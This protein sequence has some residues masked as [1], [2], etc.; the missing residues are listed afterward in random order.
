MTMNVVFHYTYPYHRDNNKRI[1]RIKL[2]LGTYNQDQA[3]SY[4]R[5]IIGDAELILYYRG[6][7]VLKIMIIHVLYWYHWYLKQPG[8]GRFANTIHQM[9]YWK[10]LTTQS[11]LSVTTCEKFQQFD[12]QKR[13]YVHLLPEVIADINPCNLL[14]IDLIGTYVKSIRTQQ[15]GGVILQN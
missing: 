12:N 3:S 15:S 10:F 7:Y 2:K 8:G 4:Y 1:Q 9:L 11:K 5:Q 14:H 6:I 13:R